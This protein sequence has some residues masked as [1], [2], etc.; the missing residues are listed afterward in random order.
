VHNALQGIHTGIYIE[1]EIRDS[2]FVIETRLQVDHDFSQKYSRYSMLCDN[3]SMHLDANF[4]TKI[5]PK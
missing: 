1:I 5:M 2:G 3:N 4:T